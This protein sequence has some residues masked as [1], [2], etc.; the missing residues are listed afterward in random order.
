MAIW[1]K[2]KK[3]YCFIA[4]KI[5]IVGPQKTGT[6]ALYTFLKMNPI[7]KSS[8]PSPVDY[9]EVQFFNNKHYN[10][11]VDWY[12]NRFITGNN[13]KWSEKIQQN[14]SIEDENE[15]SYVNDLEEIYYDKSATYFDDPQAAL[16]ASNLLPEAF[17]VILLVNP[18]DRAYSWYQ[19]MKA[20]G[21]F[22]ANSIDFD[23]LI[24]SSDDSNNNNNYLDDEKSKGLRSLRSRCLHPGYY[25]QHLTKW[26]EYYDSR[27]IIIIDG[28]W[29]KHKP[30]LVMN[31]LQL[32]LRVEQPLDYDKLLVYSEEKG[33]YCQRLADE[34]KQ[35][36]TTTSKTKEQIKC[37]GQSKGRKYEPMSKEARLFLNRHYW[38]H[39]RQLARLLTDIGQP[40]PIWMEDAMT[41]ANVRASVIY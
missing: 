20:H 12:F 33:F 11:G 14:Y 30:A 34:T 38:T 3:A 17:I 22:I 28:L 2:S 21:D 35:H 16:R 25:F 32:L 13:S 36:T 19:H 15:N 4:P 8:Q 18:A 41:F 24:M 26:L 40:L 37:L 1:Q 9:E 29:F 6:T 23:Q 31:K 10:K 5:L 7:F 39:N 27:K